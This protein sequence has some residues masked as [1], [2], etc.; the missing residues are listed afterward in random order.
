MNSLY[1]NLKEMSAKIHELGAT[2]GYDMEKLYELNDAKSR[3][4]DYIR[5]K[6]QELKALLLLSQQM[7][8]GAAKEEPIVQTWFEFR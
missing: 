1:N 8:E 5:N 4:I 2:V 3:D 6:T 7:I